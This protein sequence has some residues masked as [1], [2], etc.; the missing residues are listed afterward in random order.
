MASTYTPAVQINNIF[1]K[2]NF[3]INFFD[4]AFNKSCCASNAVL[5]LEQV[6]KNARRISCAAAK[7]C[8]YYS[9]EKINGIIKVLKFLSRIVE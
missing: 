2:N 1:N 7:L 4:Y 9:R 6:G 3:F 8:S 5:L